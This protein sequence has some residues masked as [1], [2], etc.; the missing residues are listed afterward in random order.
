MQ[1]LAI[2]LATLAHL[3]SSAEQNPEVGKIPDPEVRVTV[4]TSTVS[5][6]PETGLCE[7]NEI[8][9]V[10]GERTLVLTNNKMA[11]DLDHIQVLHANVL[12]D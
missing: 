3:C 12:M 7:T 11:R 8:Y 10:D 5:P 6:S 4:R 1:H 9:I 2:L